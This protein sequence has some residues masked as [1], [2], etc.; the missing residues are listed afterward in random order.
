MV[1]DGRI[2]RYSQNS[3]F[4][5]DGR[6]TRNGFEPH[7]ESNTSAWQSKKFDY[8][9]YAWQPTL[10]CPSQTRIGHESDGGKWICGIDALAARTGGDRCLVYSLGSN[11]E[12]SFEE[13]VLSRTNNNCEI[14]IFDH[15]VEKWNVPET[16][17]SVHTHSYAIVSEEHARAKGAPYMSFKDIQRKLGHENRSISLFK[18][19]I[20]GSEY[21]VLPELLRD[22]ANIPEQILMEVHFTP[23]RQSSVQASDELLH[24][25]R[26][27]SYHMFHSEYNPTSLCCSEY[28]FLR[29]DNAA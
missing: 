17:K 4:K 6:L 18:I 3:V 7:Y 11:N 28:S 22:R 9:M 26:D 21:A 5:K 20:E 29:L 2:W 23:S 15:T 27:S 19:D 8:M 16:A 24:L 12:F 10:I 25:L 1:E 13:A 14:H